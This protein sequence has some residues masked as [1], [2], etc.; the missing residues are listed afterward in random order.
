MTVS[1][2]I[3]NNIQLHTVTMTQTLY[4][5]CAP[6]IKKAYCPIITPNNN[7]GSLHGG[8]NHKRHVAA[9]GVPEGLHL[10]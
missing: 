3:Y 9:D 8:C 4:Q 1:Q 10:L 2:A 7:P 6:L 5:F